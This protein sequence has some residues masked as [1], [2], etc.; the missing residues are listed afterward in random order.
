MRRTIVL[1]SLA[2]ASAT[3][4]G[5]RLDT[6]EAV[7][8]DAMA[9]M[10]KLNGTFSKIT[11]PDLVDQFK[12]EIDKAYENLQYIKAR[13]DALGSPSDAEK[14]RLRSLYDQPLRALYS[15]LSSAVGRTRSFPG[16][17][18]FANIEKFVKENFLDDLGIK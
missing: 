12:P 16:G 4:F 6:H 17:E 11:R 15:R 13:K 8:K 10:T 14:E 1:A 9:E 3:L 2:V 7:Y 5:C 18:N